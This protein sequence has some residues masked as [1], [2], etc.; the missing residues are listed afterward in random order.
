MFLGDVT[1]RH[2]PERA[3]DLFE[4]SSV[5]PRQLPNNMVLAYPLRRLGWLSRL[6]NDIP[7]AVQQSVESLRHNR[8][9]GERVG[10]V[11]DRWAVAAV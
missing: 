6:R 4:E 5:L 7:L 2:D 8:D 10:G 3:R 9:G 11:G 1:L